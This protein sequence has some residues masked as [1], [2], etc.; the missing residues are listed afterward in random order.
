MS[1]PDYYEVLGV[2]KDASEDEIKKAYR[3]A[4]MENHPDQN[5]D[6]PEAEK[7]FKL[8]AEA[9]D[10]L[11]DPEKRKVY[12]QYGHEGLQGSA[13]RRGG[14]G[15]RGG[16]R[17]GFSSIDEVFD[18]FGDIF[19]D[20]FGGGMGG[21]RGRRDRGADLRYDMELEFEEAAFG[22]TK[23]VEIPSRVEC[24][25]CNGSGAKPG[26][27]P[28]SCRT[29]DGR[30]QVRQSQ[31]FFTLASTCPQCNGRGE[32]IEDKCTECGGK[33]VVE[34]TREV[35]VEVPAGVDDGTRLRLTGEGET[36]QSGARSGDLYVFL[37][38]QPH[39]TFEREGAD[40]HVD[41]DISFVQAILGADVEVP[42]L[43]GNEEITIKPGTQHG[44]EFR[45]RNEGIEKIRGRGLGDLIA[46]VNIDIPTDL[47][48]EQ[49]E[50]L[51]EYAELSDVDI[52]KG[53]FEKIKDRVTGS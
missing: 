28:T 31:G 30:G 2:S 44:D 38:V 51:E 8:A 40:L 16:R 19:G 25:N 36:G 43:K 23:E 4:A 42:T 13:G 27:S 1:K 10:V 18:Q 12:D 9:Y 3:K 11:S 47:K 53:F 26:T 24:D 46:T 39:E 7:Q 34:E 35:K 37:H 52:K 49:R 14:R 50:L 48:D 33:G 29:C 22:T 45:L 41:V 6:D 32:I 5:P 21:G 17:Q 20:V 15:G